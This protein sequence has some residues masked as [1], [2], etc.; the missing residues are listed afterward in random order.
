VLCYLVINED[1]EIV[2]EFFFFSII[3]SFISL[4]SADS[5][6]MYDTIINN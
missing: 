5:N 6:Y 3:S 1:F 4:I 2:V